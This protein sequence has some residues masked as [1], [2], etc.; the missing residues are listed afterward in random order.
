[1][2]ASS[3]GISVTCSEVSTSSLAAWLVPSPR[4]FW[5]ARCSFLG[6]MFHDHW[7]V[8]SIATVLQARGV[9]VAVIRQ[10][11]ASST[12][13]RLVIRSAGVRSGAEPWP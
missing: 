5:A 1:M 13:V 9:T 7:P 6:P 8:A 10:S 4:R 11:R 2:T 12:R 3:A